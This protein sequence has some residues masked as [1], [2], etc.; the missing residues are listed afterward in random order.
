MINKRI[1][2]GEFQSIPNNSMRP[3]AGAR[4]DWIIGLPGIESARGLLHE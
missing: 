3:D 1:R 2:T 4:A